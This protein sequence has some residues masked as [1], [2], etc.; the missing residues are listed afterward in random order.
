MVSSLISFFFVL[1]SDSL[2]AI[3]FT[4]FFFF[5]LVAT[6]EFICWFCSFSFLSGK[7]A[8]Y[9]PVVG[10]RW[11]QWIGPPFARGKSVNKCA[12]IWTC[13][14]LLLGLWFFIYLVMYMLKEL[15]LHR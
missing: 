15:S 3:T 2:E 12:Q 13:Y 1:V 8:R 7:L 9:S 6:P 5:F 14:S 11:R 10:H 4:C